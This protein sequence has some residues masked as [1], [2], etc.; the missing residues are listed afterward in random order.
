M[1]NVIGALL[2]SII[3]SPNEVQ[4]Q[5]FPLNDSS[6]P[7]DRSQKNREYFATIPLP[8]S[9]TRLKTGYLGA[10]GGTRTHDLL[11]T[12]QLLWPSELRQPKHRTKSVLLRA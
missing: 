10:D 8:A 11:I 5:W 12:N 1:Q 3:Y 9:E 4:H 6:D 7:L 2:A